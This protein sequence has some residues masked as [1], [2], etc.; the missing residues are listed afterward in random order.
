MLEIVWKKRKIKPR[1][2]GGINGDDGQTDVQDKTPAAKP[3]VFFAQRGPCALPPPRG[4]M[5]SAMNYW[6][7]IISTGNGVAGTGW[8]IPPLHFVHSRSHE[9]LST[10]SHVAQVFRSFHLVQFTACLSPLSSPPLSPVS[11]LSHCPQIF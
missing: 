8:V 4:G 2:H 11:P 6:A 7:P 5:E 1:R 3:P 10:G 9:Y